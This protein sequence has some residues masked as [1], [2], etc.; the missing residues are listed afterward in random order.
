MSTLDG[1]DQNDVETQ[2]LNEAKVIQRDR[3][4]REVVRDFGVGAQEA[5]TIQHII[6]NT[7]NSTHNHYTSTQGPPGPP[8]PSGQN[9]RDRDVNMTASTDTQTDTRPVGVSVGVGAHPLVRDAFMNTDQIPSND[10]PP[11]S[12]PGAQTMTISTTRATQ[13]MQF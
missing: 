2:Q 11:P 10:S 6:N 4:I 8:G 3:V 12:P 13:K 5:R 9:G 7:D 1:E